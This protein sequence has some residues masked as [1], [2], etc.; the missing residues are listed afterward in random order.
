MCNA[1]TEDVMKEGASTG[2]PVRETLLN[3]TLFAERPDYKA[4]W[5]AIQAGAKMRPAIPEF[6]EI[7]EISMTALSDALS[8]GTDVQA[9]MDKAA[10]ECEQILSDAGYYE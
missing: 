9:A 1:L 4:A 2:M 3:D 10:E 7:M 8:N 5:E 6:S